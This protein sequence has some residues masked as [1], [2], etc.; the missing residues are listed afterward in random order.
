MKTHYATVVL[1]AICVTLAQGVM[2]PVAAQS[3]AS[4]AGAR[5]IPRTPDGHP[6][7]Q[8]NWTNMWLTPFER[9]EGKGPVYT[10]EEVDE[11]ERQ[12][13]DCPANPGTVECGR[14]D[15][16]ADASQSNESRLSGAEYNEVYWDRGSRVA[17]VHGE[18]RTSFVTR[19]SN[20]RRPP[21]TPE[22]ERRMQENSDLR[23]YFGAYDHPELRPLGERC[24]INGS[25]SGPVGP[26]MVPKTSYNG[27]Y[28]IVQ[29]ADHVMIMT[30]M[31]HDVRII[32]IG[33]G[34]RLPPHIRPWFG[35][36]WGH[37][38][39]DAL[40]VETTNLHPEQSL[41]G[42]LPSEQMKVIE[43]FTRVDQETILYEFTVEDPTMYTEAWGGEIPIKKFDDLLYEYACHEGNYSMAG[44]LGGARY[45]EE[46][47]AQ[48]SSASS[49]D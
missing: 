2:S 1:G 12:S 13:G 4:N 3:P 25:T 16:Q 21:L 31:I 5:E 32:S 37:W 29:T 26:P 27:N 45:Q 22:G 7:I 47:Q 8:G 40:V 48:G 38:E 14:V 17:V 46:L 20:G 43:R 39:G 11:M 18:P 24:V 42:V 30:E 44:V 15:N 19:P 34:P 6:D 41:Q 35:D 33:D 49:R 10:S 23:S 36:S 9:E 28:T